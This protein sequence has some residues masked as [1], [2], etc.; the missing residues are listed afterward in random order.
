MCATTLA[1]VL[2]VCS[3]S[4]ATL[5]HQETGG[6]RTPPG[7]PSVSGEVLS[8]DR[9]LLV[10]S[11]PKA[12]QLVNDYSARG[13]RL[14][15]ADGGYLVFEKLAVHVQAPEYLLLSLTSPDELYKQLNEGASRGFRLSQ[16]AIGRWDYAVMEKNRGEPTSSEAQALPTRRYHYEILEMRGKSLDTFA[17]EVAG[18]AGKGYRPVAMYAFYWYGFEDY[19]EIV[20][21]EAHVIVLE[22]IPEDEGGSPARRLA[23]SD[24]FTLLRSK[25]VINRKERFT[26]FVSS[27]GRVIVVHDPFV[28]LERSPQVTRHEYLPLKPRSHR[29]SRVAGELQTAMNQAASRG[30]RLRSDGLLII[31]GWWNRLAV[32][33]E[34]SSHPGSEIEY[35][36]IGTWRNSTLRTEFESAV[37]RGFTPLA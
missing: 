5:P 29:P 2:S 24:A 23:A 30:F 26:S 25:D 7:L 22:S 14:L 17:S 16:P 3:G 27:G 36:V 28:L 15:S 10:A 6:F 33:M 32:V 1:L 11:Y 8:P 34:R 35:Q 37:A 19:V 20:D 13:F 9:F 21:D 31:F 18:I 12:Q 4:G